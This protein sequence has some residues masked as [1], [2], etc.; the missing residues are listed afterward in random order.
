MYFY[1]HTMGIKFDPDMI[2]V[3]LQK[4]RTLYDK[5]VPPDSAVNCK[6]CRVLEELQSL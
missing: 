4:T 3:L 2:P 6:D 5:S 1:A